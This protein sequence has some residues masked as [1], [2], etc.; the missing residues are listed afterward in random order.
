MSQIPYAGKFARAAFSWRGERSA[1]SIE[2]IDIRYPI[3]EGWF[4]PYSKQL[5]VGIQNVRP[6]AHVHLRETGLLGTG[7]FAS[8]RVY[9]EGNQSLTLVYCE[10]FR[11]PA[12]QIIP[13]QRRLTV[14]SL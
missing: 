1:L 12:S 3:L 4:D 14:G 9:D 6:Y 5:T 8:S 2:L 10:T 11:S 13:V 7:F